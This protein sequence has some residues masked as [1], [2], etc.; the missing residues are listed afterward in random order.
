[1]GHDVSEPHESPWSSSPTA[2]A[3]SARALAGRLLHAPS[4]GDGCRVASLRAFLG[5]FALW[6][7][8]SDRSGG[9]GTA[10]TPTGGQAGPGSGSGAT[11]RGEGTEGG[12]GSVPAPASLRRPKHLGRVRREDQSAHP[13]G[14]P[15]SVRRFGGV[16]FHRRRQALRLRVSFG[17][18]AER[19]GVPGGE[20]MPQLSG[21]C[22]LRRRECRTRVSRRQVRELHA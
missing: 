1:M 11:P 7:C 15:R 18:A 20:R 16:L 9:S 13:R 17:V 6:G 10:T 21:R 14:H 12:V 4:G 3:L 22:A 2:E 8:F 19:S 5:N